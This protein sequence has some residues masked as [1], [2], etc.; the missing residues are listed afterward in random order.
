MP[1]Y[2]P[3]TALLSGLA[4]LEAVAAQGAASIKDLHTATGYPKATLVR[5]LE[6]LIH[7]GYVRA[8]AGDRPT[9]A[10]TARALGLAVRFD[11]GRHLVA[12]IGPVLTEFQAAIPWPSDL[13]VFDRDAMVILE[14]SRRP[15]VLSVNRQIGSRVP[16][17]PT[18]LGRAYLAF[19]PEAERR[20]CLTVLRQGTGQPK[21]MKR[22]EALLL[23]VREKGYASSDRENRPDIR[24]LAAPVMDG[25]RVRGRVM[26]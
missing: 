20:D 7:A 9:Y 18:A 5:L 26:R 24:A 1:S 4:V 13:A 21:D 23:S 11:Q 15:G 25:T 3:V 19:L 8:S 2:A 16:A 17:V 6:T 10:L 22:F 12:A 14:T